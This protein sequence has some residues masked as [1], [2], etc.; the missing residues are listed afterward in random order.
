M[1]N[2]TGINNIGE[3]TI[4]QINWLLNAAIIK[5]QKATTESQRQFYSTRRCFLDKKIAK[6]YFTLLKIQCGKL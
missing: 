6:I 3:K 5:H 2:V 4:N 1:N